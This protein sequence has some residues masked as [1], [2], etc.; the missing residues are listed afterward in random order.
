MRTRQQLMDEYRKSHMN[1][2]NAV[3]HLI[4]VPVIVFSSLGLAW[5]V[6]LGRWMGLAPEI[7]PY[8]N[9]ATVAA[10]LLG[11]FY[12]QLSIGSL[13]T[14]TA[15]FAISVV[16]ILAIEASGLSLFWTSA[17]LWVLSWAVQ[18]YGHKVEG[19]KPSFADDLVFFLIGPLFVMDKLQG[20]R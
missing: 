9:L 1:P 4:C 2:L 18:I 7:A 20:R 16:G 8:V 10:P 11:L 5:C 3:I 15:W 12:L 6:P 19:A 13:I 14:M 17:V